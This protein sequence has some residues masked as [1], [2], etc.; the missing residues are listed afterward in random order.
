MGVH[1]ASLVC[2]SM[3]GVCFLGCVLGDCVANGAG[4]KKDLTKMY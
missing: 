2:T 4:E 3:E 1:I